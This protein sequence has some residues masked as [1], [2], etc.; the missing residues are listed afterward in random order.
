MH[1]SIRQLLVSDRYAWKN[2][3]LEALQLHPEVFAS[4]YA[5]EVVLPDEHFNQRL[6]SLFLFGAFYNETL[7]A[8]AGYY[9]FLPEKQQHKS[10]LCSMY[11]KKEYRGHGVANRLIDACVESAKQTTLQ[12]LVTVVST[13][14][15]A[16]QL[17]EKHGFVQ[18]GTEPKALRI[19]NIFYD[20]YLMIRVF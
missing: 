14:T 2:L 17:Y 4:S 16:I 11:V 1:F 19:G 8:M 10:M 12:M 5:E 7:I 20:E 18:Y 3:R 15:V 6:T 13:N 9:V